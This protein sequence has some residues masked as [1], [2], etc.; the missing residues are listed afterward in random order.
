MSR[1]GRA[2]NCS[3]ID[4]ISYIHVGHMPKRAM[5]GGSA[6][7]RDGWHQRSLSGCD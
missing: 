3:C 2:G 7:S 4:C 6:M 1:D 5:D